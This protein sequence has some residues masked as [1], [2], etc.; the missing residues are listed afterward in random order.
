VLIVAWRPSRAILI[1]TS[2]RPFPTSH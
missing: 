1:F 2:E